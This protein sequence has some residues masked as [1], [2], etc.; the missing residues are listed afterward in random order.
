MKRLLV[1]FALIL[2][3]LLASCSFLDF[4]SNFGSDSDINTESSSSDIEDEESDLDTEDNAEDDSKVDNTDSDIK[5]EEGDT[6][7]EKV[8]PKIMYVSDSFKL[9]ND[10]SVDM[11]KPTTLFTVLGSLGLKLNSQDMHKTTDGLTFKGYDLYIFEGIEPPVKE[12]FPTDGSVWLFNPPSI[13]KNDKGETAVPVEILADE[14]FEG[15]DE[16]LMAPKSF[17]SAYSTITKNIDT[18]IVIG[19]G[20]YN[21]MVVDGNFKSIFVYSSNQ[22]AMVAGT[23]NGARMV[24]TSFSF[25]NTLWLIKIDYIILINNL[26]NYSIQDNSTQE[27][28]IKPD[29]SDTIEGTEKIVTNALRDIR[30]SLEQRK[31]DISDYVY[32]DIKSI[33][34]EAEKVLFDMLR[35]GASDME[36]VG[37]LE[38]IKDELEEIV[39]SEQDTNE[40][41]AD[42]AKDALDILDQAQD[43]IMGV[44]PSDKPSQEQAPSTDTDTD[45]DDDY[46]KDEKLEDLIDSGYLEEDFDEMYQRGEIIEEL[47]NAI[48]DYFEQLGD[49]Q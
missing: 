35:N 1:L 38:E 32:N 34:E 6:D 10:G 29:D 42:V 11:T 22:P 7:K 20:K 19:V 2:S 33:I 36:I 24:I 41:N 3:L 27:D 5:D 45:I 39:Y 31:E 40:A 49:Q 9:T 48:K 46:M 23:Y 13:P 12:E 16:M 30:L 47:Y 26:I 17:S 28:S 18:D 44:E 8:S 4:D 37:K 43:S 21:P 15:E 14:Q 25:N